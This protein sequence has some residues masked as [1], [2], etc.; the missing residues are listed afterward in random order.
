[1]KIEIEK[2]IQSDESTQTYVAE[3]KLAA[4]DMRN[5]AKE[6]AKEIIARK[7]RELAALKREEIEKII[8][9]AQSKAQRIL[10]ET[11]RYLERLR[12]KKK[13]QFQDLIDDL[14][15]RVTRF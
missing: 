13:S 7:E 8:S 10:E 3:A 6:K 4:Q 14:I 5:Q 15:R 9:E 11:D 2:I 12:N 1:M